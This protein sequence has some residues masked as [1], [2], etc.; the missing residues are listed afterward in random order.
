M[1]HSPGPPAPEPPPTHT[2]THSL[3]RHPRKHE[4]CATLRAPAAQMCSGGCCFAAEIALLSISTERKA[5]GRRGKSSRRKKARAVRGTAQ[6]RKRPKSLALPRRRGA[7]AGRSAGSL[8]R[9]LP[10]LG[11]GGLLV[12]RFAFLPL[13]LSVFSAC[14]GE[15]RYQSAHPPSSSFQQRLR[16]PE[17]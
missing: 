8:P 3:T 9:L 14:R 1:E 17:S 6:E 15:P 11:L 16:V 2:H 10:Q 13:F 12:S 7:P 4:V 5:R